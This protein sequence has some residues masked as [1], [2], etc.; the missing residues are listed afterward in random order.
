MVPR[1]TDTLIDWEYG[2]ELANDPKN[3]LFYGVEAF[4]PPGR[5]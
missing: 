2:E 4:P 1:R 3:G 5:T